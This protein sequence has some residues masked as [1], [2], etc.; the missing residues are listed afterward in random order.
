MK[1]MANPKDN[2]RLQIEEGKPGNAIAD[3][4]K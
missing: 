3:R 4:V 1:K 2:H